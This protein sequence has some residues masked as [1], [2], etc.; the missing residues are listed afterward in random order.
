MSHRSAAFTL[1]AGLLL[2]TGCSS[3]PET[4]ETPPGAGPTSPPE[5]VPGEAGGD[6][7]RQGWP[8]W[9]ED[10]GG[11]EPARLQELDDPPC[12]VPEDVVDLSDGVHAFACVHVEGATPEPAEPAVP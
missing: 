6:F 12:P 4:P 11:Q 7:G 2:T 10:F 8:L 9:T 1:F 3:L 5:E